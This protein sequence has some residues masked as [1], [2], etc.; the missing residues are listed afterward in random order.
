MNDHLS[1]T[2][3]TEVRVAINLH[4]KNQRWRKH[5]FPQHASFPMSLV[6]VSEIYAPEHVLNLLS[7][8]RHARRDEKPSSQDFSAFNSQSL[9]AHRLLSP[10]TTTMT[11]SKPPIYLS[12]RSVP[13]LLLAVH[14]NCSNP[15]NKLFKATFPD[16][17]YSRRQRQVA[18]SASKLREHWRES[19]SQKMS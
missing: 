18:R 5:F 7:H 19:M 11:K 1:L 6:I 2:R 10:P 16:A 15:R 9:L 17:D 3:I 8:H 13:N 14:Q 12:I 4:K